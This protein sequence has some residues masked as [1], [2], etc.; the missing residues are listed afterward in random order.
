MKDLFRIGF[1]FNYLTTTGGGKGTSFPTPL[2]QPFAKTLNHGS[3]E[4]KLL[5][6]QTSHFLGRRVD[7]MLPADF[8][9]VLLP[10]L[11][12]GTKEKNTAVRSACEAALVALL[13]LRVAN[14]DTH[15]QCVNLL[16]PGARESLS[17]VIA[18]VLRKLASQPESKEEELDATI[19]S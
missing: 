2:I 11:V 14:D 8:L 10:Q 19:V 4:V 1:L 5:V 3:N 9:K 13:R 15:Q 17:E 16:D 6:A 7:F 12:N 18:K